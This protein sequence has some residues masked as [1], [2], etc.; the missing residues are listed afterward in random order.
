MDPNKIDRKHGDGTAR[1]RR[2][3]SFRPPSLLLY[4]LSGWQ[5][6]FHYDNIKYYNVAREVGWVGGCQEGGGYVDMMKK[7]KEE[8]GGRA[9]V[10]WGRGA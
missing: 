2:S 1:L 8:C 3:I 9:W 6:L 7:A 10:G 5:E 4:C